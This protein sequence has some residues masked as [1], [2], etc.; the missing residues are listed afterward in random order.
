MIINTKRA[1]RISWVLAIIVVNN[2]LSITPS[3][4]APYFA[5]IVITS[6]V[7]ILNASFR[8]I[9]LGML[10]LYLCCILSIVGNEIPAFFRSWERFI[11]FVLVTQLITPFLKSEYLWYIRLKVFSCVQRLFE[12]V[13]IASIVAYILGQG[14]GRGGFVG[15]TEQAMLLAPLSANTI[16]TSIYSLHSGE[17]GFKERVYQTFVLICAFLCVLMAASRT[18]V[19]ATIAAAFVYLWR[20]NKGEIGKFTKYLMGILVAM[21]LLFPLWSPYLE[22]IENKNQGS[23]HDGGMTSSREA[24]WKQRIVE[25]KESPIIGIGFASVSTKLTKKDGA[26]FDPKTGAVEPGTSWL[27]ALSMTGILGFI[28]LVGIFIYA[29]RRAESHAVYNKKYAAYIASMIVFWSFHMVAEGYIFAGGS[30]MFF[31]VWLVIGVADAIYNYEYVVRAIT[32]DD[33]EFIE[34]EEYEETE[35]E[36]EE[37]AYEQ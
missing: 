33:E 21:F 28:S 18:A 34:Y 35:E 7:A 22:N 5:M 26:S 4:G 8:R 14:M 20:S 36:N 9:D 19:V 13:A 27:A 29:F 15:I 30:Y 25:W 10:C 6:A 3:F 32:P 16:I 12:F 17:L 11:A 2:V 1:N 31:N 24:H 37:H 23:I